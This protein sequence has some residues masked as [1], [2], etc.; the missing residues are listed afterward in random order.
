MPTAPD[1]T[2]IRARVQ[3][4][5]DDKDQQLLELTGRADERF[6]GH[7]GAH[8]VPRIQNYGMSAHCPKNSHFTTLVPEGNPDKAM[9]VGGEDPASRP[10]NL[11]EGE[12]KY[13]SK[14]GQYMFFK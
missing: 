6:G 9:V 13:Y 10:K 3:K 11:E 1:N 2:A 5:H 12:V 8:G 4:T 7:T 14:F